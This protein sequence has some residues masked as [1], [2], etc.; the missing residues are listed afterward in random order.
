LYNN[1]K[2]IFIY[3]NNKYGKNIIL[4]YEKNNYGKK[5]KIKHLKIDPSYTQNNIIIHK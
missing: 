4:S 1:S 5:I 2:F 3:R